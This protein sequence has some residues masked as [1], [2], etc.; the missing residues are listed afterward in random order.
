MNA[1]SAVTPPPATNDPPRPDA[2]DAAVPLASL[3]LSA[4]LTLRRNA[5]TEANAGQTTHARRGEGGGGSP[6]TAQHLNES[7]A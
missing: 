4:R 2:A 5:A 7:C 3:L 6:V 1:A